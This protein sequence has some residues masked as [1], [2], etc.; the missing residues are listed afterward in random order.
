MANNTLSTR[1]DATEAQALARQ[2]HC[3]YVELETFHINPELFRSVPLEL[4]FRHQFVPLEARDRKMII[5]TA[6]PETI[7][8]VD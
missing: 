2:Y 1:N 7:A 6:D 8:R 4:M 3:E 5:A